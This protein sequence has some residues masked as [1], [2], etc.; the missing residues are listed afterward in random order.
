M[1][2]DGSFSA[3]AG[4]GTIKLSQ[5]LTLHDTLPV[6]KLSCNLVSVSKLTRSLNYR[7]IFDFDLCEFQEKVSG[8]M[9]GSARESIGL[10]F[11]VTGTTHYN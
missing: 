6:P 3:I 4:K 9:I 7:A 5:S 11:L 1:I 8:K 2:S 10:Y